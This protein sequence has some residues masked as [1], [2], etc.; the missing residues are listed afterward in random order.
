[1]TTNKRFTS[2]SS[3]IPP[4]FAS[5]N[6]RCNFIPTWAIPFFFGSAELVTDLR[7]WFPLVCKNSPAYVKAKLDS[8]P[9]EKYDKT[10]QFS[11]APTFTLLEIYRQYPNGQCCM[12]TLHETLTV[13]V[14]QHLL[15]QYTLEI[16]NYLSRI[17]FIMLNFLSF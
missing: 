17:D 10:F 16:K 2:V 12:F 6:S 11:V 8:H 9:H 3:W 1:M 15:V 7:S 5:K 14:S 4:C 13:I